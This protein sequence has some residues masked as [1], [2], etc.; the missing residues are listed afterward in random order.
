MIQFVKLM[1]IRLTNI[2]AELNLYYTSDSD[3]DLPFI[4]V[5]FWSLVFK[6]NKCLPSLNLYGL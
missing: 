4:A 6:S 5:E 3:R 1:I 2:N